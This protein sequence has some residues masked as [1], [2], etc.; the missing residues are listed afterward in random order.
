ML[1][2]HSESA[3]FILTCHHAVSGGSAELRVVF[4]D[5]IEHTGNL[6]DSDPRHDLALVAIAPVR[7][8]P[9]RLATAPSSGRFTAGGFGADGRYRT[10]TGALQGY[11]K[12]AGAA[13][14]SLVIRGAVRSGDSG[15]PVTNTSGELV[16]VVW[17]VRG[18]SSYVVFGK[19]VQAMIAA[20]SARNREQGDF[21][22]AT[23]RPPTAE[24]DQRITR[25]EQRLGKIRDC[26]C[27]GRCVTRDDL[28]QFARQSDVEAVA[29]DAA[30]AQQTL[31]E[32]VGEAISQA[33]EQAKRAA[34]V[35][36]SE[37]L[38]EAVQPAKSFTI[39]QVLLGSLGIGGPTGLAVF[40]V[41]FLARRRLRRR[42][43][44]RGSGG[45]RQGGFHQD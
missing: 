35:A 1:V 17:G 38:R 4:S 44:R 27:D 23:P 28:G 2:G 29:N 30:Q 41:G 6:I 10:I 15:G 19:P 31:R 45:P 5:R 18:A 33:T 9:I 16:G 20:I 11:A 42:L 21:V 40:A 7:R 25:I 32:R 26:T 39:L 37:R 3:S 24:A 22:E 14:E 43:Q 8:A 12:P 34:L 36:V 13:F